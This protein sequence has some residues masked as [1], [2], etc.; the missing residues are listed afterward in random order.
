MFTPALS[1]CTSLISIAVNDD[2]TSRGDKPA[3]P[4]FDLAHLDDDHHPAGV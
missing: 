2:A 3:R 4:G 1:K